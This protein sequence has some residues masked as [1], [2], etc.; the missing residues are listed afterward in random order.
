MNIR[1]TAPYNASPYNVLTSK[2]C[3]IS[4]GSPRCVNNDISE[5]FCNYVEKKD[6]TF[7]RIT[8]RGD[9]VPSMPFKTSYFAH[10]C[11]D[12]ASVKKNLRELVSEDCNGLYKITTGKPGVYYDKDLDC[13]NKKGRTYLPNP[14][15]HTIYLNIL[16]RSAVDIAKFLKSTVTSAEIQRTA[17]KSTECRLIIYD[18]VKKQY[19]VVFFDVNTA[20]LKPVVEQS[21]GG[22]MFGSAG[23]NTPKDVQEDIRM[24]QEAFNK[25]MESAVEFN[26]T[27]PLPM[28]GKLEDP[29]TSATAPNVC[30]KI[31]PVVEA[32]ASMGGGRTR[33]RKITRKKKNKNK[34][35]TNKK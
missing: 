4:L 18:C 25:L 1:T 7:L 21:L 23:I 27:G 2:I 22:G 9:P 12:S 14:L 19:S 24:T 30:V 29:F 28:Q 6:I 3:C 8:T 17:T 16:Y 20:R 11:S 35:R 5:L 32:P 34:S 15:K 33:K 26:I 31:T 13:S 10:P